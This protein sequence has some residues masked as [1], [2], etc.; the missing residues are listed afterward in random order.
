MA[1]LKPVHRAYL[2]QVGKTLVLSKQSTDCVSIEVPVRTEEWIGIPETGTVP[3][4]YCRM[5]YLIHA[6]N[7][8]IKRR[9]VH[10]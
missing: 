1:I 2:T 6:K 7:Q 5:F 4:K 10:P 8:G 9:L 3:A